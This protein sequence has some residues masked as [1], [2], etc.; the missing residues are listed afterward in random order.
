[1]KLIVLL[2]LSCLSF[3]LPIGAQ[4][5][6]YIV[7]Q[8]NF[9][10]PVTAVNISPDG[11]R[12]FAGLENGNLV[13][14]SASA[15]TEIFTVE[16]GSNAAIYDIEISPKMDVIFIA[17]GSRIMLYDSTGTHITNWSHHKNTIWSMDIDPTGKF[18]V[19][20]EVNKTFQLS[21]IYEGK[22]E[23]AMRGHDDITLAVAFSPD[24][25]MIASGSNDKTVRLWSLETRKVIQTFHGISD[26]IY[27]VAFSPDGKLLAAATKD[28]KVIIWDIAS[29]KMLHLLIGHLDMVLEI[30]FS[31]DGKYLLSS[32]S[33][34]VIKLWDVNSG[35]Q[36]CSFLEN[37][38]SIP[39]IC[40]FPDGKRFVSACTD[41]TLAVRE[42]NPEIF[43]L[44]YFGKEFEKEI[45]DNPL[46]LPK[47][48][49]E[50]KSDYQERAEKAS[51]FRKALIEKY[52]QKYL[53]L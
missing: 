30:E 37:E 44:K 51:I 3:I 36:I 19:S 50:K 34:Q 16:S 2:I 42:L 27:D 17:A 33:D 45:S 28:K 41:G 4:N 40:F 52:Y 21:N 39:D 6:D 18:L 23:Q 48:K 11:S 13:V 35:E 10:P 22:I 14:L 9:K 20:T 25:K 24:G 43:V 47:Q 7:E 32:S 31:P 46:F 8:A 26:N 38:G 29:E 5:H 15:L 53:A 1:M 49:G 12:I